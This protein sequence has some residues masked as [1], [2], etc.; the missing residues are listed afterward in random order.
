M[1]FFYPGEAGS[2]EDAA[3]I[4]ELFFE[5]LGSKISPFKIS[6]KYFNERTTGIAYIKKD[7][8]TIG[9]VSYPE[10]AQNSELYKNADILLLTR[11]WPDASEFVKYEMV[12]AK[13]PPP[14]EI[15][16]SEP[17]SVEFIKKNLFDNIPAA[18]IVRTDRRMFFSLKKMASD[19]LEVAAILTPAESYSLSK[20]SPD[21]AKNLI[22]IASS[23]PMP[24]AKLVLFSKWEGTEKLKK[25]L[26]AMPD[27]PEGRE[28]LNELRLIGFSQPCAK[29]DRP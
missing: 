18:S 9:I 1:I 14:S 22:K 29:G 20:L 24:S 15:I 3:P 28:I 4:L 6:G 8:P 26:L 23:K 10:M 19:E 5:Y 12:A 25:A 21:W 11:P 27:D 2:T 13:T 7:K 17:M 16:S